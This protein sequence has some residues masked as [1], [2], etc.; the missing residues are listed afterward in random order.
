LATH[1]LD[2][3]VYCSSG[4]LDVEADGDR[5][6]AN[7]EKAAIDRSRDNDLQ[8]SGWKLL[9]F[10]THQIREELAQYCVPKI[11]ETI[12]GMGGVD[13]G[14]VGRHIPIEGPDGSY[15]LGLFRND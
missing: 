5:W 4:K 14:A 8:A 12:N 11:V 2:F 1:F 15:Q 13:E 10:G 6:H 3:A 9:R 7:R